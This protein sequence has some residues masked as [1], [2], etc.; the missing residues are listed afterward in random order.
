MGTHGG[1]H[2]RQTSDKEGPSGPFFLPT[3]DTCTTIHVE[4]ET[5]QKVQIIQKGQIKAVSPR[6]AKIL[7]ALKK[8]T[9]APDPAEADSTDTPDPA[10]EGE[11]KPVKR[12]YR[13]KDMQ[14]EG[15]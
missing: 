5:M 12:A 7:V 1:T 2:K 15:K 8:A 14:A 4:M 6:D 11:E 10:T 3:L 13:R 9:L